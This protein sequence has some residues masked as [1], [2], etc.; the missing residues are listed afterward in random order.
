MGEKLAIDGG[1]PVLDPATIKPWP[2]IDE[3][4][5][6]AVLS[7]LE[8]DYL[9]GGEAPE[10][11][12][13]EDE[14][15]R[16]IGTKYCLAT[17]SGT[18]ALHMAL[19]ALNIGPGDEVIV[20]A[21]TF[22]ASASCV[23]HANAVPVFVDID[24]KTYTIDPD[25]IEEKITS[26]TKAII[27]VHLHGLPADMDRILK[28][29]GKQ[30]LYVIEDACQAHGAEY[31]GRKAGTFG[32]LAAFSLNSSKNLA[33]GEGGL[34]V[35]KDKTHYMRASMLRM[36][37]DEIDDETKLRVYN[38]SILGYMYRTQ[39]LSAA[40]TRAQLARLDEYNG[41]RIRNCRYLSENLQGIPGLH[42][43]YIPEGYKSV[44]WMYVVEFY[45]EETGIEMPPK[46][47]RIGMEKALFAEGVQVGQWQ[48]M[49]VPSQ[50]LFQTKMGFSGSG[51][52]WNFTEAGKRINYR[53]E[54]YPNAMDLCHRYTAV[55]GFQPPNGIDLMEKYATAFKKVFSDLK[56]VKRHWQDNIVA[57]YHGKLFRAK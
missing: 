17:S 49:P 7:V 1:K 40:F 5:K 18:A 38:A 22:L 24:R 28:I 52:P 57:H 42:T 41:M 8:S 33:G 36:F 48:T 25:K 51:Y 30:N 12:A 11:K 4:D 37:G 10:V 53:G 50:D 34:L 47:F 20:P 54:D 35:M 45:P 29:A 43:P 31:K 32:E 16:Y 44:Y 23:L 6:K 46:E 26:R 14:W 19:T 13:L 56:T 39:E 2:V 3:R 9:C 55:V 15:A 27:P 21:Y